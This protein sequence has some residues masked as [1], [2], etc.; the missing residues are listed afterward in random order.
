MKKAA[1]VILKPFRALG[2]IL[3]RLAGSLRFLG[4][5]F[6]KLSKLRGRSLVIALV[7][8]VLVLVLLV[9][10]L[11]PAPDSE[12]EVRE[13]L[14]RFAAATRD[15]D[16]QELCDSLL[17]TQLVERIRSAGLP[18]EVALKLGLDRRRNPRL[19]VLGVELN[20]DRAAARVRTSA[21]AEVPSTDVL[22]LVEEDG[23]RI[24][25]LSSE[26]GVAATP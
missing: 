1:S 2:R 10:V 21:A 25:S 18:C 24:A 6:V 14:D 17:A 15:K 13:T 5:P 12:E 26:F 9:N 3:R 20:G 7:P 16:Y 19:E 4:K 11:R 23:W 22:Q 8:I